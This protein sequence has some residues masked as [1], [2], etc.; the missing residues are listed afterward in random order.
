MAGGPAEDFEQ[1][2]QAL[3]RRGYQHLIADLRSVDAIDSAGIRALVRGHSTAQRMRGTFRLANA[4]PRVR[5]VLE[6]SRL[7]GVLDCYETLA[8]ASTRAF[9]WR[10]A[11]VA[12]S[13]LGGTATLILLGQYL[14]VDLHAPASASPF[15]E[16]TGAVGASLRGP[17][18][19]ALELLASGLIGLLITAVHKSLPRERPMQRSIEQAQVLLCVSGA[20]MMII[21]GNS[22]ARAFGIAGAASIIRFRTP[23]DDPKDVTILF[24]LMGLGMA[25]GIGAFTV[26]GIGTL[27]LCA[28]LPILDRTMG[29]K[30]RVMMAEIMATSREFPSAHVYAVFARHGVLLE[31]REVSQ[32]N[33]SMTKFLA[34][35]PPGIALEDLSQALLAHPTHAIK[36][37][38]WEAPKR[39]E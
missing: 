6:L 19:G 22:I 20:M 35:I 11:G 10:S 1:R 29:A 12:A 39:S 9:D 15:A 30:P 34:T 7:D 8:A 31:P 36:S 16:P 37:V 14:P 3:F 33:E 32:G 5:E 4:G 23:V 21:I 26:A 38:E 13:V 18:V 24:L 2:I 17:L 25:C 27:F 28:A